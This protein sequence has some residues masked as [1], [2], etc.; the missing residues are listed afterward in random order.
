MKKLLGKDMWEDKDQGFLAFKTE[1]R[2]DHGPVRTG[3]V[4][5]KSES[6]IR[7]LNRNRILN[8]SKSGSGSGLESQNC[9]P[10]RQFTVS[11]VLGG[12]V[13]KNSNFFD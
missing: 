12:S 8:R 9:E 3:I 11:A 13:K 4:V 5:K 10:N 2:P 6:K 7:F 1:A